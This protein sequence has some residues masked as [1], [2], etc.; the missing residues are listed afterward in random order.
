MGAWEGIQGNDDCQADLF[1]NCQSI[2][3]IFSLVARIREREVE[4]FNNTFLYYK[5]FFFFFWKWGRHIF[6]PEKTV[7]MLRKHWNKN[8]SYRFL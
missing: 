3:G 6:N 4:N 5:E 2:P 1:G 8:D 7:G